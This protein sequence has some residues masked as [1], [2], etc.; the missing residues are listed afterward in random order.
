MLLNNHAGC[1]A[2]QDD[3]QG[4]ISN[5]IE[6]IFAFSWGRLQ[7]TLQITFK[8]AEKIFKILERIYKILGWGMGQMVFV[9]NATDTRII[10]L[11][12]NVTDAV[13]TVF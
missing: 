12:K 10:F 8:R 9:G 6:H 7:P 13:I 11:E 1:G 4:D 5:S 3:D 2:Q